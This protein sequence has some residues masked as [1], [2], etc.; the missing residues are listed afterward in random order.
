MSTELAPHR[1]HLNMVPLL[2][3]PGLAL[4]GFAW[5]GAATAVLCVAMWGA[6]IVLATVFG[7][8]RYMKH[9]SHI[10]WP[11]VSSVGCMEDAVPR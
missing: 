5:H 1:M 6:F 8:F 10:S 2:P 7:L 11:I 9:K 3:A 4:A